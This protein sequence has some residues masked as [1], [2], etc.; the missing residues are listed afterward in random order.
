MTETETTHSPTEQP[1]TALSSDERTWALVGHLSAFSAFVTVIGAVV[2][3]LIVW[4]VKRDSLPFA[5]EQ[6]KEALNFNI[7]VA[8]GFIALTVFTIMTLGVGVLLAWPAGVA[9]FIAWI[10]LTIIAAIKA[11]EGVAYRYPFTLR[12]I[13]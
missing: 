7:T 1:P 6:A 9:L 10:V 11:N 12:L 4:L 3:P 13:S 5:A 8:I 2:G